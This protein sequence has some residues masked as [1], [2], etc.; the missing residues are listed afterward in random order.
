MNRDALEIDNA[1]EFYDSDAIT[2]R[3]VTVTTRFSIKAVCLPSEAQN[4]FR[5]DRR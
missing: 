4:V 5:N 1:V 2:I 3:C